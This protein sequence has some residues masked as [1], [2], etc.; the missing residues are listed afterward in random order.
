MSVETGLV[1][2]CRHLLGESIVW[3]ADA[4]ELVWVDIHDGEIWRYRVAEQTIRAHVL[5]DRVGALGL[6]DDG[7]YVV[8]LASGFARFDPSSE[9]VRHI[10]DVEPELPTTRLNDGRVDRQG[11]FVCGGMDEAADQGPLSAVYRLDPDDTV[12]RLI[13]GIHC[14][15]STCFSLDGA[16]MYFTDMPTGRILAY[17]YDVDSGH[18]HSPR[19]F[20][21]CS[22][23]PGLPDGSTVDAE[24]YVWNARWGGSRLVRHAPD[25]RVD[26]VVPVPVTNPTCLAFG[27]DDLATLF[28]TSARFGLTR[29]Q[30]AHEPTA[31]GLFAIRPGVAG[32]PEPR[33]AG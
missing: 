30:L 32:V 18:P 26:R 5:P 24:G 8:A 16:T 33:F 25:G 15:N 31:G 12:H 28:V 10:A 4:G 29:A 6:C 7:T 3:D 14:A 13:D 9:H 20:A 2:D 1:V 17:D 11:R 19:L 21:D 22:D 27:G 23:Q